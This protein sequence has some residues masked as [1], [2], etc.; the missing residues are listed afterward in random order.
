MLNCR[1]RSTFRV[2]Q[3]GP[4]FYQTTYQPSIYKDVYKGQV[5]WDRTGERFFEI[6]EDWLIPLAWP[7]FVSPQQHAQRL[8]CLPVTQWDSYAPRGATGN[9]TLSRE[10]NTS[11]HILQDIK[12]VE[13][14]QGWK[15]SK[16][17]TNHTRGEVLFQPNRKEN[18]YYQWQSIT[19]CPEV[20]ESPELLCTHP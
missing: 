12:T 8:G 1:E 6:K 9:H 16:T 2:E 20:E 14:G 13:H 4:T 10:G 7:W 5:Y 17:Q 15:H 19:I 11:T 3:H 18:V